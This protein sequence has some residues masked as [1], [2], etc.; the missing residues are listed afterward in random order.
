MHETKKDQESKEWLI[1]FMS[2]ITKL[3]QEMTPM[4]RD[5]TEDLLEELSPEILVNFKLIREAF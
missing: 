4:Q 2:E 1:E 3:I 5:Q